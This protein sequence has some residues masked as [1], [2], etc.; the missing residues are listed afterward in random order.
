MTK[1]LLAVLLSTFIF[2]GCSILEKPKPKVETKVVYTKQV[3]KY[4][5]LITYKQPKVGKVIDKD[6][7]TKQELLKCVAKNRVL[8]NIIY[9]LNKQSEIVN[10]KYNK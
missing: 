6:T 9:K 10:N 1:I 8:R 7:Y 5:K 2:S 3:C 4:P